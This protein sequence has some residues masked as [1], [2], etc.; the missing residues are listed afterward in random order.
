[1]PGPRRRPFASLRLRLTPAAVALGL[2]VT[3]CSP[4]FAQ[5]WNEVGDAGDVQVSVQTPVGLYA[6]NQINGALQHDADVDLYCI[7]VLNPTA[8]SASLQCAGMMDPSI[9]IFHFTGQGVT[10]NDVCAFGGKTI[11]AAPA[12]AT[13]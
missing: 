3:V 11:P 7:E 5:V 4:S 9:W 2:A 1:M 6:L 10:H 12:P 13:T 8:F